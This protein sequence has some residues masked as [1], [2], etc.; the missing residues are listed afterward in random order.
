MGNFK[1]GKMTLRSLFKKPETI[2]Y[3]AQTRYQPE[4]LKGQ[5]LN[6]IDACILC[7]ICEKRC[8]TDAIKV[9]KKD[10]CWQIDRFRCVQC[11]TCVRE[12][13]KDSLTMDPNYP[14][15]A[16]QKSIDALHKP[17]PSE[18]EKAVVAAKEAEKAARIE[19]AL[20]AKAA[21]EAA[22]EQ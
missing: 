3:P 12:C 9:A 18:D 2:M 22:G 10:G 16:A 5:V 21:R 11:G 14:A 6:D 7:G 4:G 13:P 1:L 17:E 19:A 8:P 15:P 20:A